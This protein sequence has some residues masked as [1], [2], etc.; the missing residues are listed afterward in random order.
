MIYFDISAGIQG[1][2]FTYSLHNS[3]HC[4][5]E[6][7]YSIRDYILS[8]YKNRVIYESLQEGEISRYV[9]RYVIFL[10]GLNF[11]ELKFNIQ[12]SMHS[13][14]NI[15]YLFNL[16]FPNRSLNVEDIEELFYNKRFSLA[17]GIESF[18]EFYLLIHLIRTQ[19]RI[20]F[21]DGNLGKM[22]CSIVNGTFPYNHQE[23]FVKG[24]GPFDLWTNKYSFQ[25]IREDSLYYINKKSN[26]MDRL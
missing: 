24:K 18:L 1:E 15:S 14:D 21:Y 16:Y 19:K 8:L 20:D 12:E 25:R 10:F 3:Y 5:E 6:L 22:Y 7:L 13:D 17:G 26:W 9:Y 4:R 2:V 23:I 11:L